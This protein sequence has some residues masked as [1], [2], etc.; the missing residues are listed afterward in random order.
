MNEMPKQKKKIELTT[1]GKIII[2]IALELVVGIIIFFVVTNNNKIS[3]DTSL[4]ITV[5]P[6]KEAGA[7]LVLSPGN[8]TTA[9]IKVGGKADLTYAFDSD[10]DADVK[11]VISDTSKAKIE[12]GILTALESGNIEIYAVASN[13]KKVKSNTVNLKI[14][15]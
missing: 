8:E 13:N 3:D 5:T 10:I 2:G 12:N 11:W 1:K 9:G 6:Q 14:S 7:S 15:K 4:A